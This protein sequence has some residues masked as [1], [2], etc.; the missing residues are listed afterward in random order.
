MTTKEQTIAELTKAVGFPTT[1]I[2]NRDADDFRSV[3]VWSVTSALDKAYEAGRACRAPS[4][5][6]HATL[7]QASENATLAVEFLRGAMGHAQPVEAVVLAGLVRDAAGIAQRIE[8]LM[9]AVRA[10]AGE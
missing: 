4:L 3:A 5:T 1:E 10:D 8:E 6:L 2:Q 9:N 7:A